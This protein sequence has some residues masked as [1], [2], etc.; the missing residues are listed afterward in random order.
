M[1]L[2]ISEER[3]EVYWLYEGKRYNKQPYENTF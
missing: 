2:I 1:K 3:K